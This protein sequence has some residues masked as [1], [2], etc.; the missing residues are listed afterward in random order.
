MLIYK[1]YKKVNQ[2][3][4]NE[5]P[6]DW[7]KILFENKTKIFDQMT[8]VLQGKK[9]KWYTEQSSSSQIYIQ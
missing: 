4:T 5:N 1:I 2:N 6:S 7:S 9:W 8:L 3:E